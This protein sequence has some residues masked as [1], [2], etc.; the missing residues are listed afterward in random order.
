[1]KLNT[2]RTLLALTLV[3]SAAAVGRRPPARALGETSDPGPKTQRLNLIFTGGH[4]T[5]P[6]D[7]RRPVAL[8]AAALGV[9]ADVFRDAFSHVHPAPAGEAP[10]EDQARQNKRPLLGALAKYGVT[11]ERLDAVS[12]YYRYNRQRDELW[13]HTPASGYAVVDQGR[14][15]RVML[16]NAGAGYTTPPQVAVEGLPDVE[17]TA[18]VTFSR[19]LPTN[20]RLT[21][22]SQTP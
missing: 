10:S 8:I 4:E 16:T 17:I 13:R 3:A 9:P 15:Q 18:A 12:D 5:D 21:L 14:V 20:G 1:M 2:A 11:N 19:D 7:H 22:G 6:R